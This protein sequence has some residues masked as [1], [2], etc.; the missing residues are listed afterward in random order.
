MWNVFI[1][2]RGPRNAPD[3][4]W[5]GNTLEWATT[6]PPPAYNF[7]SLPPIRSER[8]LFDLQA[9]PDAGHAAALP[10]TRRDPRRDARAAGTAA[11]TAR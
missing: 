11:P 2:L 6:S 7:D 10:A 5:E 1:T 8:P 4:P 3:D 9:R